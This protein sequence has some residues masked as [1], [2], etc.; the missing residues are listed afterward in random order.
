MSLRGIRFNAGVVALALIAGFAVAGSAYSAQRAFSAITVKS[1]V[2]VID[3]GTSFMISD[4]GGGGSGVSGTFT[5][6][7]TGSN[8][9]AQGACKT[10][11]SE[12]HTLKC[13]ST[14]NNRCTGTCEL[15]TTEPGLS[16]RLFQY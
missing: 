14:T 2:K 4:G 11:R 8:G 12:G 7:C 13:V 15:T 6:E 9:T 16:G 5:C 10:D 1:G 3:N